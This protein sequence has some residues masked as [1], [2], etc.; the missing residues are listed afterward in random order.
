MKL[1]SF[2]ELPRRIAEQRG[3]IVTGY[4]EDC[5]LE[6]ELLYGADG[7]GCARWADGYKPVSQRSNWGDEEPSKRKAKR[8]PRASIFRNRLGDQRKYQA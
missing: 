6:H 4:C 7:P 5:G 2:A 1:N 8:A 3:T